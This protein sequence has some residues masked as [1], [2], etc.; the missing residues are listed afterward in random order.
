MKAAVVYESMFGNTRAI[1]EAVAEGLADHDVRVVRVSEL[2]PHDLDDISLVVVGGPTHVRSL[3]R[4]STRKGAEE[5][6]ADPRRGLTLEPV[7]RDRGLREWLA[8]DAPH[9]IDAAAFDTRVDMAQLITG[10]ASRSIARLLQH[11]GCHLLVKPESFVVTKDTQLVAGEL[12][13]ARSWGAKVAAT[14]RPVAMSD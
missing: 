14:V 7:A 9:G 11:N 13:R 10:A 2:Q 1:A 8:D 6:A 3:S 4:P 12:A 5:Q